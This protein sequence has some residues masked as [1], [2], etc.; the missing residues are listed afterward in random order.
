MD[1]ELDVTDEDV[2]RG[3]TSL[4][5]KRMT[6]DKGPIRKKRLTTPI[7]AEEKDPGD[8]VFDYDEGPHSP[9]G[10]VPSTP[11]K[12]METESASSGYSPKKYASGRVDKLSWFRNLDADKQYKYLTRKTKRTRTGKRGRGGTQRYTRR[13]RTY[14]R[15]RG[16]GRVVMTPYG[17]ISGMGGYYSDAAAKFGGGLGSMAGNA[18]GRLAG[19]AFESITGLGAYSIRQNS[20][21]L[22]AGY[23][24]P[25]VQNVPQF[26]GA[27]IVKHR[28]YLFDLTSAAIPNGSNASPFKLESFA[29]N[30]GNSALF[31]WLASVAANFQEYRLLGMIVE[32]KDL[33]SNISTT[34]SLGSVFLGTDYNSEATAPN[35]KRELENMEYSTSSKPSQSNIHLIECA[36]NLNVATHLFIIVDNDY[37]GKDKRW[38]DIGNFHI[39][40]QGVPIGAA[41]L[42]EVWISYQVALFKPK[43]SDVV[44]AVDLYTDHYTIT[45][46]NSGGVVGIN[47]GS[48]PDYPAPD[49][50]IMRNVGSRGFST[51][52]YSVANIPSG[53]AAW[54]IEFPPEQVARYRI[55]MYWIGTTTSASAMTLG[56]PTF[57][58]AAFVPIYSSNTITPGANGTGN[59]TITGTRLFQ[60]YTIQTN[61]SVPGL[62][63]SMTWL[64]ANAVLPVLGNGDLFVTLVP[65]NMI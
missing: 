6:K 62:I 31:P 22:E 58:N 1:F 28:E 20:L 45:G 51:L 3:L 8:F 32:F 50:Y 19:G 12:Q 2:M 52:R 41:T 14:T 49:Q 30:P 10:Q 4:K 57:V 63:P 13:R 53:A 36:P 38:S 24:V 35:S 60:E 40:S 7:F 61:N 29:I 56:T 55:S 48:P 15:G 25:E 17:T 23:G 21:A 43:I 59:Q 9:P 54:L 33:S 27:V 42:G 64:T 39:G 37:N 47:Y 5:R 44:P 11:K 16:C 46:F 34:L 18:L 65:D 26:E